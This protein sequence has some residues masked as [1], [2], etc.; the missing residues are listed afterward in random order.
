[1]TMLFLYTSKVVVRIEKRKKKNK[2]ERSK[3]EVVLLK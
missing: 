3:K 2:G 1:M